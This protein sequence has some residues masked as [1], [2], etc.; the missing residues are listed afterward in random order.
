MKSIKKLAAFIRLAWDV[1]PAYIIVL[2]LSA[3][4]SGAQLTANVILPKLL[5]DELTGACD[6]SRLFLYTGLV[7]AANFA[8]AFLANT[9][10]RRL[11][12]QKTYVSD[13]MR[14]RMSEKIMN[15][16]YACL[17]DPRMLDLKEKAV[18]GLSTFGAIEN[19]VSNLATLVK[20][21]VTL[22]GLIAVMA[23]L[24]PLLIL[25]LA[26]CIAIDIVAYSGFSK[27]QQEVFTG[28]VPTNRQYGYYVTLCGT[29]EIQKDVRLYG[30]EDMLISRVTQYNRRIYDWLAP[31]YIRSGAIQGFLDMITGLEA[32]IAY[33]FVGYRVLV[34]GRGGAIS[35]GSFTMYVTAA[36]SF[37]TAFMEFSNCIINISQMLGYLEPFMEF[38][39]VPDERD[40]RGAAFGNVIDSIR[41]EHVTFTYPGAEKPVLEDISFAVAGGEHIS[42]VGLNGA[43]KTTIVKLLCR[44]Y[45]PDSGVILVNGRS[46]F[47]YDR[48]SYMKAVAAVFQDYKLFAFTVDENITCRDVGS[49][50]PGTGDAVEKAGLYDKMCSLENGI[51]T[52]LGKAYDENGTEF[53]GGE[54][55]KVAIARALY[56]KAPLVILDEPTSALDPIAE[57][58]IYEHFNSLVGDGTAI[59]ISH[60]MSSSVFCDRILVIDA[61]RVAA[62]APHRKLM[63]DRDGLYYKLFTS[64]AENYAVEQ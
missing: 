38:M 4:V 40:E 41:F 7:V 13:M 58:E 19:T 39:Q 61:G 11:S 46:I 51:Y 5:I 53:S 12:Y 28:L 32:A 47:E 37:T 14:E 17:E 60:R 57:A 30:M 9:L 48:A 35:L 2:I 42:I 64:Q 36:M 6:T 8:F 52:M 43:G 55:Q 20:D 15:V 45:H 16:E 50:L 24:S 31:F 44:L 33:G 1:S 25:L 29:T 34:P 62:Y 49:D 27:Y 23:T 54:A 59:Y 56:K 18:F 26:A 63:E 22:L 3:L 10:N 21:F